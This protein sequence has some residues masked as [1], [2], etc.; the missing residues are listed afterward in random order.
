MKVKE[1]INLEC[2][3]LWKGFIWQDTYAENIIDIKESDLP[4]TADDYD[5]SWCEV[6]ELNPKYSREEIKIVV[7]FYYEDDEPYYDEPFIRISKWESEL[8]E[9]RNA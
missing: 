2:W 6:P 4:K 8:W 7:E 5:W 9:E 1:I 3:D